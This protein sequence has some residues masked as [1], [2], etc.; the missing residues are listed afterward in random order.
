MDEASLSVDVTYKPDF[1]PADST[2]FVWPLVESAL[3][4]IGAEEITY[5]A[6]RNALKTSHGCAALANYLQSEGE[7]IK[8]MD[9]SFR[10]PLL[11]LVIQRAGDDEGCDT[12]FDPEARLI[13]VETDEAQYSF[14]VIKDYEVD[15]RSIVD[16]VEIGYETVV[17]EEW[18]LDRL[19]AYAEVEVDAY[20]RQD[21]D[22]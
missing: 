12:I 21:D 5:D 17:D 14:P 4:T 10:A 3:Q 16:D 6:A 8:K 13:F 15:W 2:V 11:C 19:L 9:F 1:A 7:K 18:A 22:I 20:R